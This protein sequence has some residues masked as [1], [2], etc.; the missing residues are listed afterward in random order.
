VRPEPAEGEPDRTEVVIL[1]DQP[2]AL[3]RELRRFVLQT[4]IRYRRAGQR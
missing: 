2:V 4:Q 3:E 1:F